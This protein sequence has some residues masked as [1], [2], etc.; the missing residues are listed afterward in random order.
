MLALQVLTSLTY[1]LTPHIRWVYV[2][3][4]EDDSDF[5]A[6]LS[7]DYHPVSVSYH[8]NHH[9]NHAVKLES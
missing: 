7:S 5:L 2:P 6:L 4:T 9:L 3:N 1:V 8:L